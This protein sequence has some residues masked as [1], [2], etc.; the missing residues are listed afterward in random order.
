MKSTSMFINTGA[1][2]T[3][4]SD[5]DGGVSDGLGGKGRQ[6]SDVE[7]HCQPHFSQVISEMAN[8]ND[9]NNMSKR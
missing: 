5:A 8:H 3:Y 4:D 2:F 7:K 1:L 9:Q 6:S